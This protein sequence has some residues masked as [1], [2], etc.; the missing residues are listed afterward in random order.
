[1]DHGQIIESSA[2]I[3]LTVSSAYLRFVTI[4]SSTLKGL[5]QFSNNS[6]HSN[7]PIQS[8]FRIKVGEGDARPASNHFFQHHTLYRFHNF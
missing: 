5:E 3:L 4:R 7:I 8:I 2:A 1:M 6:L